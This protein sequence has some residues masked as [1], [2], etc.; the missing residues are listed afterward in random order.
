MAKKIPKKQRNL[1]IGDH[2]YSLKRKSQS[3]KSVT[4]RKSGQPTASEKVKNRI[5]K[6]NPISRILQPH[7]LAKP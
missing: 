1:T 3:G 6:I 4:S 7:P 2:N 5:N